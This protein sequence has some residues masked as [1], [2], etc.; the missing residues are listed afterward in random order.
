M[1][2]QQQQQQVRVG[3]SLTESYTLGDCDVQG[4]P[5]KLKRVVT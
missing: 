2:Q 5:K 4:G 1:W 3:L